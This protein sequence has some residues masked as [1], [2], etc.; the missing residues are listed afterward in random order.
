[1]FTNEEIYNY[2][3]P[4]IKDKDLKELYDYYWKK[5]N[6]PKAPIYDADGRI[7]FDRWPWGYYDDYETEALEK[8]HNKLYDDYAR[9]VIGKQYY[10]IQKL[11]VDDEALALENQLNNYGK[12]TEKE[13]FNEIRKELTTPLRHWRADSLYKDFFYYDKDTKSLVQEYMKFCLA[14]KLNYH[15][16]DSATQF[17][18]PYRVTYK[19]NLVKEDFK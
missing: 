7:E 11:T 1:M 10:N 12:L 14:H 16:E 19:L 4:R 9:S 8:V 3:S 5:Y 6:E 17:L 18:K 15:D 2:I 13:L